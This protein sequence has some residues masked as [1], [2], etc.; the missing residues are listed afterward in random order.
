MSA[1][2]ITNNYHFILVSILT[3]IIHRNA[4]RIQTHPIYD[5]IITPA[6]LCKWKMKCV[7]MVTQHSRRIHKQPNAQSCSKTLVNFTP[8]DCVCELYESWYAAMWR[9][10]NRY[11][12]VANAAAWKKFSFNHSCGSWLNLCTP[13]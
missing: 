7:F 2:L 13:Q 12:T 4:D 11:Q 6:S 8:F 5:F 10:M 3:G 1:C 9:K